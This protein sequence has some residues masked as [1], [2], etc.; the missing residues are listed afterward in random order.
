M[1]ACAHT[2]T[3]ICAN[4]ETVELKGCQ[5]CRNNDAGGQG[6]SCSGLGTPDVPGSYKHI[7]HLVNVAGDLEGSGSD[8][9]SDQIFRISVLTTALT[10]AMVLIPVLLLVRGVGTFKW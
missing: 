3:H 8:L 5:G 1:Y 10:T 6:A 7:W 9:Q 4:S 2:H